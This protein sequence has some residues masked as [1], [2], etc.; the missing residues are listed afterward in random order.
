M[1]YLGIDLGTTNSAVAA[2]KDGR[3]EMLQNR[4]GDYI[5]PSVVFFDA[6]QPIVGSMARNAAAMDPG[7]V[8]SRVKRQMGDPG[9]RA[10]T[11]SGEYRAEDV[12]AFILRRLAEDAEEACA[13]KFDHAIVTVPAYFADADR[14]ATMDAGRIAG[15]VVPQVLNEPTAAALAYGIGA[16]REERIA[17]YDLGGGTFDLTVMLVTPSEI[18]SL[19][20]L[21]IREL[22]G[23]DWD[24]E[25]MK[26]L[27]AEFQKAGGPNLD[28]DMQT[29]QD[30][31][32]KTE[33]AKFSLSQ[34]SQ[35]RVTLSAG[36]KHQT[37]TVTRDIFEQIT[38][39][40]LEQTADVME[41]G[42]EEAGLEWSDIDKVLLVGGSTRMPAVAALVE[43]VSGKKP[44]RELHPDQVVALGAAIKGANLADQEARRSSPG[45]PPS[46][47][48][49][50]KE[51][52]IT[53]ITAHSMGYVLID[54]KTRAPYSEIVIDRGSALPA[55][56]D[57]TVYTIAD[58]ATE[59][60]VEVTQGED[61]DL[62]YVTMVGE[63]L[64]RYDGPKPSGHPVR[65]RFSYDVNGLVHIEAFDGVTGVRFGELQLI[66]PSNLSDHEI[67]AA[68]VRMA[69]TA[70]D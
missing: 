3:P 2:V 4:E 55:H 35:A 58:G 65:T 23:T 69:G 32:D 51:V 31:R 37:V 54:R 36:G 62:Q 49:G 19:S 52:T 53:D 24:N 8:V 45:R 38:G 60:K 33:A 48:T 61:R 22:G 30:L 5:T 59:W 7:N 25:L 34:M 68:R 16:E 17:V 13:E 42:V 11:D 9:W 57:K 20:S 66:R 14:K 70:A 47:S 6:G 29:Q 27:N 28:E 26:W 18:R 67:E 56:M 64:I 43:K 44:S 15:L 12:S 40:L 50:I 46:S 63:G 41:Q 1:R 39:H 21:G 10:I